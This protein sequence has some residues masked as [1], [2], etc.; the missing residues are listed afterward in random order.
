[1]WSG[2]WASFVP[3]Y[4]IV[5]FFLEFGEVMGVWLRKAVP[6]VIHALEKMKESVF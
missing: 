6:E 1:M 2:I 3:E 4:P 5:R